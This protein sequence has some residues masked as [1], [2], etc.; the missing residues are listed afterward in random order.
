M[1][2][3]I[4]NNRKEILEGIKNNIFKKEHV[5]QIADIRLNI[6]KMCEN[7]DDDGKECLVPGTQPCCGECGCS[8]A[9]KIR[10]LSSG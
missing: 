2:K 3:Q 5:E 4:F 9:L 10:S 8:L 7:Y 1:L 6:C